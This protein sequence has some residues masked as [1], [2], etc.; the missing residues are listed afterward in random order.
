MAELISRAFLMLS[1][2]PFVKRYPCYEL[3]LL[4]NNA[5]QATREDARA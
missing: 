3:Q 1:Y 2:D 5:L 4:P